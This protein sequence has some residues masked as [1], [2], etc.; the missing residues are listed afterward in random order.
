[1]EENETRKQQ[2]KNEIVRNEFPIVGEFGIPVIAKQEIDLDTIDL[3]SYAKTKMTDT[4]NSYKTIHFFTY[5]WL[6]DVTYENPEK[7]L[8][9][10]KQYYAV[11][12]PDFSMYRNMPAA[13]Q[14]YS[15]F[16]NRWC[17][18]YWQSMGMKVIPTVG[19]AGESSFKFCFDGIEEGSVVA[20]STY[21]REDYKELFMR[22]YNK[23]LEVIKPSAIICYG[24]PFKEMKGKIKA[25][26]PYEHK[27][28]V[29]KLGR[30]E[31]VK[32]FFEGDLYPS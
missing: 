10:L 3:L 8:D 13:L 19:W 28:L 32:K 11:L 7:V 31:Y 9:K 30:E 22:G 29:A 16:R 6:F 18:A 15:T 12:T 14:I 5:D 23:M 20:V 2:K 27:E 21:C 1:M 26:N 24:T 4:E 17:G 25:I